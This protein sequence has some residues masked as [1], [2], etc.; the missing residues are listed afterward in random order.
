MGEVPEALGPGSGQRVVW[1][2]VEGAIP[3][4][5]AVLGFGGMCPVQESLP[6]A[7][8]ASHSGSFGCDTEPV[9]NDKN[10]GKQGEGGSPPGIA[11]RGPHILPR[12]SAAPPAGG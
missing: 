4:Q 10:P 1:W 5:E 7:Q 11:E 2:V 9:A 3:G 6:E 12:C 8:A